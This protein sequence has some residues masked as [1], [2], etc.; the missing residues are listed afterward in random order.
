MMKT[1]RIRGTL[2]PVGSH[3]GKTIYLGADHR[4]FKL[5]EWLK[6]RLRTLGFRVVD[7]GTHSPTRVDYPVIALK[8]ARPVGRTACRSAVGIGVCGSSIGISI[9]AG[10][11]RG[12]SPR[13]RP[14][15]RPRA[16]PGRTTTR[17]SSRCRA[18]S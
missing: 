6:P 4:G 12:S 13:T 17:T 5:K 11:V 7:V 3:E 1:L 18:T 9:V 8:V 10:K 2:V 14:R 15:S 16:R